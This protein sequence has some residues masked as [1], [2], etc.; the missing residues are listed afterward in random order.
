MGGIGNEAPLLVHHRLYPLEQPVDRSDERVE[1]ARGAL[2]G[3]SA[4]IVRAPDVQLSGQFSHRSQRLPYDDRDH[5]HQAR[6][7]S[8]EWQNRMKGAVAR[9]LVA[10]L[11]GLADGKPAAVRPCPH[12]EPPWLLI[13]GDDMQTVSKDPERASVVH[14]AR[15]VAQFLDSYPCLGVDTA[16]D[17]R[18]IL[19]AGIERQGP[20]L[21]KD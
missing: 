7:E 20:D 15:P 13:A 1:F 3:K 4:Q 5:E 19:E 14:A 18:I 16:V 10:Y 21:G 17:R 6:R 12:Q 9:D 11:G 8:C 2:Q